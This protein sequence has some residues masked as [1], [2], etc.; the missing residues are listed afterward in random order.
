MGACLRNSF[1][2]MAVSRLFSPNISLQ[3]DKPIQREVR[4]AVTVHGV[5]YEPACGDWLLRFGRPRS[6]RGHIVN[7]S[8]RLVHCNP[9]FSISGD[10]PPPFQPA[11]QSMHDETW[12]S[13]WKLRSL[14]C[15]RPHFSFDG[16]QGPGNQLRARLNALFSLRVHMTKKVHWRIL[17]TFGHYL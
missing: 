14:Y 17:V 5:Q 12:M 11:C 16:I 1:T 6:H 7:S 8:P 2:D 15:K 4:A 3:T 13:H 10:K 9:R